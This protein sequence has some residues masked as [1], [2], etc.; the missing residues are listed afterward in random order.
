MNESIEERKKQIA[1]YYENEY[2]PQPPKWCWAKPEKKYEHVRDVYERK[3]GPRHYALETII[4]NDK[5][6]AAFGAALFLLISAQY[7]FNPETWK[8][9]NGILIV[10]FTG[11]M[12]ILPIISFFDRRPKIVLDNYGLYTQKWEGYIRW[13]NI[14]AVYIKEDNNGDTASYYLLVH[15]YYTETDEFISEEYNLG[16]L[17]ESPDDIACFI[18]QYWKDNTREDADSY[19]EY[20]STLTQSVSN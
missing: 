10:L 7:W 12:I 19:K 8:S 17:E 16:G 18:Y 11:V 1:T 2:A 20:E 13:K 6:G 3:G 14:A 15:F 5:K 4:R 9:G